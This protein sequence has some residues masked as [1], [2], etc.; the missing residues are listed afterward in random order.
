MIVSVYGYRYYDPNVGRWI[1]RDP[2]EEEG[3][4]NLYGFVNNDGINKFDIFG[5]SPDT[6]QEEKK[7]CW[8]GVLWGHKSTPNPDGSNVTTEITELLSQLGEGSEVGGV[9]CNNMGIPKS[10]IKGFPRYSGRIGDGKTSK[11]AGLNA[12]VSDF[13]PYKESGLK[14][15]ERQRAAKRVGFAR[16]INKAWQAA[17]AQA[18][19]NCDECD[20]KE[21]TVEFVCVTNVRDNS[22]LK[23]RYA[24]LNH[25]SDRGKRRLNINFKSEDL[26]LCGTKKRPRN[27]F[28]VKVA[29]GFC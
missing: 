25:L 3:G 26:P 24:A 23:R 20:C 12:K 27:V 11:N 6:A 18:K 9:C 29:D 21:I 2:I 19:A 28:S 17:I 15:G 8:V 14:G 5:L 7:D 22:T 10:G 16:L 13:K 4:F 1:N